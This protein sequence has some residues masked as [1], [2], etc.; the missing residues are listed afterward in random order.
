[1]EDEATQSVPTQHGEAEQVTRLA[2][3]GHLQHHVSVLSGN[4]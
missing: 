4:I 2:G 1:M 3:G